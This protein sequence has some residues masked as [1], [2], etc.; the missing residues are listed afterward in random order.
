MR[1][2]KLPALLVVRVVTLAVAVVALSIVVSIALLL[3]GDP[4]VGLGDDHDRPAPTETRDPWGPPAA[5]AETP[6]ARQFPDSDTRR[7]GPDG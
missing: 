2:T 3:E 7:A 4:E 5:D 1:G 6:N